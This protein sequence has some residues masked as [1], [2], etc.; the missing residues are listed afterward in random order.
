[1]V[2]ER[3]AHSLGRSLDS[4]GP[5][6]PGWSPWFGKLLQWCPSTRRD[7]VYRRNT[8]G[9]YDEDSL[10]IA[11]KLSL[12]DA[13]LRFIFRPSAAPQLYV[14]PGPATA[15]RHLRLHPVASKWALDSSQSMSVSNIPRKPIVVT[16]TDSRTTSE[17]IVTS[18]NR[19]EAADFLQKWRT[20][21]TAVF[22]TTMRKPAGK[23]RKHQHRREKSTQTR[24]PNRWAKTAGLQRFFPDPR[25]RKD[26]HHRNLIERGRHIWPVDI[27]STE[28][29]RIPEK[30]GH[31]KV[32]LRWP[33][34]SVLGRL[35]K[36][37]GES[38]GYINQ[39]FLG[40]DWCSLE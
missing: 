3:M 31:K 20:D 26:L 10:L 1:M 39:H 4:I 6:S 22:L 37:M 17:R 34:G 33:W 27:E 40:Y 7:R 5:S 24:N 29:E 36:R 8:Y 32:G 35:V 13:E 9:T 21:Q 15:V 28:K 38:S 14:S 30:R 23:M 11:K 2:L 25:N 12:L 18:T 19:A 16:K